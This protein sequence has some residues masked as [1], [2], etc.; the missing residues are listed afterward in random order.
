VLHFPATIRDHVQ[1]DFERTAFF[2]ALPF[3]V[4][5]ALMAI[6]R[7]LM[8][9]GSIAAMRLAIPIGGWSENVGVEIPTSIAPSHFPTVD[10][11]APGTGYD[12]SVEVR[13]RW[14]S[15]SMIAFWDERARGGVNTSGLIV[16]ALLSIDR[17]GGSS[18]TV[19]TV[20]RY[21]RV[22]PGLTV[23]AALLAF[24]FL[25]GDWTPPAEFLVVV[26]LMFGGFTV[27]SSVIAVRK[28]RTIY[29]EISA[30]L[31]HRAT[32]GG[33]TFGP[34]DPPSVE[35]RSSIRDLLG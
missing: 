30:E 11:L 16:T 35:G 25:A 24:A 31:V 26:A 1:V 27:I 19:L 4:L 8:R 13:A 29:E 10:N 32:T 7:S 15:D 14:L 34:D 28:L 5:G 12:S 18:G 20:R 22:L 9:R 17:S 2:F 3:M 23:I 6:E 33:P 21:L